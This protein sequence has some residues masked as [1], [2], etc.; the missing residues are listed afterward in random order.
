MSGEKKK[1]NLQQNQLNQQQ[2]T[3]IQKYQFKNSK[4]VNN[5]SN[6]Q[7]NNEN[8]I[9]NLDIEQKKMFSYNCFQFLI[10]EIEMIEAILQDDELFA[11]IFSISAN[12]QYPFFEFTAGRIQ[13]FLA[14]IKDFVISQIIYS[15]GMKK[16]TQKQKKTEY[17]VDTLM[18]IL[19]YEPYSQSQKLKEHINSEIFEQEREYFIENITQIIFKQIL[20]DITQNFGPILQVFMNLRNCDKFNQTFLDWSL[21]W[22]KLVDFINLY[23]LNFWNDSE[24]E[25]DGMVLR[26]LDLKSSLLNEKEQFSHSTIANPNKYQEQFSQQIQTDNLNQLQQL[27]KQG[28]LNKQSKSNSINNRIRSKSMKNLDTNYDKSKSMLSSQVMSTDKYNIKEQITE[29]AINGCM[30]KSCSLPGCS[31]NILQ[32]NKKLMNEFGKITEQNINKFLQNQ[33]V[34]KFIQM[35]QKR[36]K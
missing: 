5:S 17:I 11:K 25:L 16:H 3:Q 28:K 15:E 10:V 1:Q 14:E 2:P 7:T 32:E 26:E 31:S 24:E 4:I 27:S 22:N 33:N 19:F 18:N 13:D 36:T 12:Q 34:K 20:E 21:K 9:A 30:N 6:L 23:E 29:H 35:Y 8:A